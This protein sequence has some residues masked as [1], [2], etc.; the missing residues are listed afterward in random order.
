MAQRTGSWT[1]WETTELTNILFV[2][3]SFYWQ[4]QKHKSSPTVSFKLFKLILS[5]FILMSSSNLFTGDSLSHLLSPQSLI[6]W[7]ARQLQVELT[8]RLRIKSSSASSCTNH[9]SGLPDCTAWVHLYLIWY[10]KFYSCTVFFF[11]IYLL[12]H[13]CTGCVSLMH[14]FV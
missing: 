1:F 8:R 14:N 6:L 13:H 9:V 5:W 12:H 11:L 10:F 4:P 3:L 7:V 2:F